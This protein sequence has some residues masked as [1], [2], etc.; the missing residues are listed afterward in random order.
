ML[1]GKYNGSLDKTVGKIQLPTHCTILFK[2]LEEGKWVAV[3]ESKFTIE[4][5]KRAG[6]IKPDSAWLK[7]PR[8]MLFSRAISQ[9]ARLFCPDAIGGIYTNEEMASV[10]DSINNI[11]VIPEPEPEPEPEPK[12]SV[13]TNANETPPIPATREELF[14]YIAQKRGWSSLTA[15]HSFLTNKLK[16]EDTRL[17]NDLEAVYYE[18][19]AIMGWA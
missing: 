8:A 10:G 6:L 9:G 5:A 11:G 7:Y 4:D 1:F 19:R 15:V 2:E 17:D 14:Q 3:G 18:V 13:K 16:V 12:P